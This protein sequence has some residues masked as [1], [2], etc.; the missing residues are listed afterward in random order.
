MRRCKSA[1]EESSQWTPVPEAASIRRQGFVNPTQLP[2][3][4]LA[5]NGR[6]RQSPG[7][8]NRRVVRLVSSGH[9]WI[10]AA[11]KGTAQGR[12]IRASPAAGRRPVRRPE[13]IGAGA[14]RKEPSYCARASCACQ[15]RP[16]IPDRP[17][18]KCIP[19]RRWAGRPTRLYHPA[20]MRPRNR[21]GTAC[22]RRKLA[23]EGPISEPRP[24]NS[25]SRLHRGAAPHSHLCASQSRSCFTCRSGGSRFEL[26]GNQRGCSGLLWICSVKQACWTSKNF[27]GT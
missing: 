19:L 7:S 13:E 6:L 5:A 23:D 24:R 2:R 14:V 21:Q 9:P 4:V 17:M 1:V 3:S 20:H 22:R 25:T 16:V 12:I 8:F 10:E 18:P 26:N 15:P 11:S 27:R